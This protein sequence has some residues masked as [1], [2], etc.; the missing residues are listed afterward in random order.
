MLEFKSVFV[1]YTQT[2]THTHTH[3][4]TPPHTQTWMYTHV[5]PL[6]LFSVC[7]SSQGQV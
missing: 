2:N 6:I 1:L 3:A 4:S 7:T 5:Q